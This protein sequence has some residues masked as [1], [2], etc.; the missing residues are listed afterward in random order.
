MSAAERKRQ[1]NERKANEIDK[2][3]QRVQKLQS[4]NE[5]LLKQLMSDKK[6]LLAPV[7]ST[8]ERKLISRQNIIVGSWLRANAAKDF[9]KVVA[10]LTRKQDVEAFANFNPA[11]PEKPAAQAS[12]HGQGQAGAPASGQVAHQGDT[13][14]HGQ[15]QGQETP[16]ASGQAEAGIGSG[17]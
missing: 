12:G 5:E 7:L 6:K 14:D 10:A 2:R 15:D 16:P 9:A 17:E 4:E 1:R 13:L 11:T 8:S 3:V